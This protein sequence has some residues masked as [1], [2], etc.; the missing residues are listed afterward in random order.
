MRHI[1]KR[2]WC[3]LLNANKQTRLMYFWWQISPRTWLKGFWVNTSDFFGDNSSKD[4]SKIQILPKF[5]H[6][7]F[8][9]HKIYT[10]LM[11]W[12][13]RKAQCIKNACNLHLVLTY[14]HYAI[15]YQMHCISMPPR[16][17]WYFNWKLKRGQVKV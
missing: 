14:A 7:K 1:L 2:L 6:P 15:N 12:D 10:I 13:L 8:Y 16:K 17:Q 9:K 3:F 4:R 5:I 11:F